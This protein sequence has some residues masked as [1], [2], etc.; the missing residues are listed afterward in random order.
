MKEAKRVA[1]LVAHLRARV[2][3]L[4][5]RTPEVQ[6]VLDLLWFIGRAPTAYGFAAGAP[7][8]PVFLWAPG[9]G[10]RHMDRPWR[11]DTDPF[12]LPEGV[13]LP[14][15]QETMG[16]AEALEAIRSIAPVM[17]R[18]GHPGIWVVVW[19]DRFLPDPAT[20]WTLLRVHEAL[21]TTRHKVVL[22]ASPGAS[23]PENLRHL[24][25]EVEFPRP[26]PEDLIP[27]LRDI[28]GEGPGPL[29]ADLRAVA[30]ALAG[31]TLD[32]VEEALT[33]VQVRL[34]MTP[35]E[36]PIALLIR[37]KAR[38]IRR[39]PALEWV[40]GAGMEEIGGLERL[41]ALAHQL[42]LAMTPEAADFGIR[43]PRGILLAGFPG[44]G[45]S[46][47]AKALGR[48][49]GLPL[50]RLDMGAVFGPYV[51]Q[52]EAAIREALRI[53]EA[54]AP[55]ILWID[56]VEKGA[57]LSASETDGGTTAR[58]LG[59]LLTWM[60]EVR[61]PVIVVA[62]ANRVELLTPEL[63]ERFTRRFFVDLPGPRAREEILRIHLR[64]RG[65]ALPEETLRAIA[66][67]ARGHSG[68]SLE[69]A[70]EAALLAA[71]SAGERSPEAIARALGEEIRRIPPLAE[72]MPQAMERIA[73]WRSRFEA[74]SDPD[75]EVETA[76][77]SSLPWE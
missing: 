14:P 74:A 39:I 55:A 4:A 46:L 70:V 24:V 18:A 7:P 58:V 22:L 42:R 48:E 57:S 12:R 8:R 3:I 61:A 59:T 1:E 5:V 25:V 37:E 13:R 53:A 76:P 66:R 68:R 20:E 32:E 36:D 34:T 11:F 63:V 72:A 44:T 71:F 28:L 52:S 75:P 19:P 51:G 60:Q 41:K 31:L 54:A 62:T 47:T 49:L 35:D 26:T 65:H 38:L 23:L 30:R 50:L 16:L 67:M 17:D 15:A 77:P 9:E 45:K 21:R 29:G 2:P 56:E 73:M 33:L 27:I 10:L 43:L 6:R 69:Q 64:K 40:E